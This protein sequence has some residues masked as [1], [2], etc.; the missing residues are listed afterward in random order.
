[1]FAVEGLQRL[2]HDD[3]G[4]AERV[5]VRGVD[6]VDAGVDGPVDDADRVVV[7]LVAPGAEHHGPEA[8]PTDLYSGG[9]EGAVVHFPRQPHRPAVC[10]GC[11]NTVPARGFS[12]SGPPSGGPSRSRWPSAH[13]L[14]T[15]ERMFVSVPDRHL[16][17]ERDPAALAALAALAERTRP[18]AASRTRLLPVAPALADLLPDGA[19]R[20]GS[21]LTVGGPGDDGALSMAL[22]LVAAAS[23]T[24]VV[25]RA[26]RP[27]RARGRGRRRPR[28]RPRAPGPPPPTGPG[29]GRG[30]G[31]RA[32]G[33]RPGRA[34]PTVPAPPGHGPT[35]G[36]PDPRA[37][38]RP[39]GGPGAGRMAGAARSAAADRRR[40]PGRGP[41][42]ARATS[43]GGG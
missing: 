18:V 36:G 38:G 26:G 35:P 37:P 8:E 20:R 19:L 28:C 42:A 24:G 10:R 33:G 23:G 16:S 5:H 40:R 12:G 34:V 30:H 32:R 21:T 7:V 41:P 11:R 13:P 31:C 22:A 6:E 17:R 2:A 29:V 39:G 15:I 4:L 9:A 27:P 14:G 43:A 25:V 1:M 3:L